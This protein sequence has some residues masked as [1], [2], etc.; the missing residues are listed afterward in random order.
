MNMV[1]LLGWLGAV[2]FAICGLPQTVKVVKDGH[3]NG[4]SKIF[5]WLW[6]WGEVST[7]IYVCLS[8]FSWPLFFNYTV[9]LTFLV[10]M[11]KYCYF[12]VVN[13]SCN[14]KQSQI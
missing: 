1:E 6:F 7:L 9:N 13:N 11:L 8:T 5:L 14:K 3:G 12:P 10:I 4:L 2:C